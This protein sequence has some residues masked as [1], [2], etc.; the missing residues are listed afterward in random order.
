MNMLIRGLVGVSIIP[1]F[2]VGCATAPSIAEFKQRE[3]QATLTKEAFLRVEPAIKSSTPGQLIDKGPLK[4]PVREIKQG[5]KVVG[6]LSA[7]DGWAG[8]LSGGAVGAFSRIGALVGYKNGMVYG[9][10]VYG[11]LD[12]PAIFVPRYV[13]QTKADVISEADFNSL[14]SDKASDTGWAYRPGEKNAKIYFRNVRVN[15]VKAVDVSRSKSTV[16]RA[17]EPVLT[18]QQIE[19]GLYSKERYN[20]IVETLEKISPGADEFSVIDSLDGTIVGNNGGTAFLVFMKG[21]LNYK[22]DYRISK[23]TS[24]GVYIVWPFGYVEHGQE[25]PKSALIF[26][27]GV[28]A[29]VVPYQ[30]LQQVEATLE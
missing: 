10:H 14:K 4:W 28:V 15:Q 8:D 9:Q 30:S 27:N 3:T 2:V 24:R 5:S 17:N 29:R 18:S 16:T 13:V 1:I 6:L 26:K 11:Y 7:S 20:D 22:G 25:V 12:G 23:M 19:K 21:Y